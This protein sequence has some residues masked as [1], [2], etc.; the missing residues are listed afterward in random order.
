MKLST[1]LF[2]TFSLLGC[3]HIQKPD[4]NIYGVNAKSHELRGYN[5]KTDY[6]DNGDRK[7]D[8]KPKIYE[9]KSLDQL[10]GWFCTDPVSLQRIKV[11]IDDVRDELK[12]RCQ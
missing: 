12:S 4:S 2:L 1:T 8:A 11:L 7:P 5:I 9:L 10:H 6:D 3:S